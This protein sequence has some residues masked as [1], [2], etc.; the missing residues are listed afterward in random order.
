MTANI[1]GTKHLEFYDFL[2]DSNTHIENLNRIIAGQRLWL[3]P[4][5]TKTLV[6]I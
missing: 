3:P 4:F 1:Y 6:C 5:I 2:R